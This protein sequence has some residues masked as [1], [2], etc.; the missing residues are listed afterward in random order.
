M[1]SQEYYLKNREKIIERTRLWREENPQ[2]VLANKKK[3]RKKH[4]EQISIKNKAYKKKIFPKLKISKR[5][6]HI[7]KYGISEE[8]Y[9]LLFNEQRGVCKI[10]GLPE[11]G[12]NLAIDHN[13]E[14]QEVRGLLC[15]KCNVTLGFVKDNPILLRK[16]T[17]YV[18]I[19]SRACC[20]H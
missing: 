9:E 2:K 5:R 19:P 14:T 6:Y 10:C 12:R 1:T 20:A 8:Q 3:Y 17:E 15:L 13:H 16:M 18:E 4:K 7:K 11:K